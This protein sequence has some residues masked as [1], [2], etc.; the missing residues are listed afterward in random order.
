MAFQPIKKFL[1]ENPTF[2][3]KLNYREV[4]TTQNYLPDCRA[5]QNQSECLFV[6]CSVL[7]GGKEDG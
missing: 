7:R 6:A 5:I 3:F 2:P 4:N 1:E